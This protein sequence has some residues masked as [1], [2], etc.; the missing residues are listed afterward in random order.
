[1]SNAA[2]RNRPKPLLVMGT[3]VFAVM[4]H[5]A[6]AEAQGGAP[7]DPQIVGIVVAADNID[8][9]Y[10]KLAASK[11]K[12][13]QVRDFAQQMIADHS[14]VQK[15]VN[16]LA[17]KLNVAPEDSETSDS[18]KAQAQQMTQKLQGLKGKQFD[19]A[20]IDNEVAYH[21][22]VINATKN[23]L[24]PSAQNAELKS[25]LQGAVPLFEGHL[26]HAQQVQSALGA[27][28]GPKSHASGGQAW[29]SEGTARKSLSATRDVV[30]VVIREFKF[31]PVTVTVHQGDTV[32]WMNHDNVPHTATEDV[33]GKKPAFDSGNINTGMAWRYVA[34]KKGSYTYICTLHPNM[35]G[36]LI[37]Q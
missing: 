6:R 37:V 15:S 2:R 30:T 9:E 20:Y 22:A 5:P 16:E 14:S 10:G 12:N 35:Q 18:L 4:L 28:N 8:I 32:E 7:T 1:M 33:E 24:I 27:S 21:H 29:N 23:V 25:A 36:T 26:Q 34:Q 17:A 3:A 13:K 31:D 11:T 19:K